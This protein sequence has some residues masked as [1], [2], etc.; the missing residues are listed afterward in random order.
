MWDWEALR[1]Q[2]LQHGVRNSLLLAPMPT[3][4]TAQIL[5]TAGSRHSQATVSQPGLLRTHL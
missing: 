2:V 1:S 5:G 3:A 4:S